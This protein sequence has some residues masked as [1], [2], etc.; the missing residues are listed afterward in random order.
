MID[1]TQTALLAYVAHERP[2]EPSGS[3]GFS[4]SEPVWPGTL[5]RGHRR[6]AA[7]II[8]ATVSGRSFSRSAISSSVF[9]PVMWSARARFRCASVHDSAGCSEP[10]MTPAGDGGL[11]ASPPA[12]P[13]PCVGDGG[14]ASRVLIATAGHLPLGTFVQDDVL[15]GSLVDAHRCDRQ[16]PRVLRLTVGLRAVVVLLSPLR[17]QHGPAG[18]TSNHRL[19]PPLLNSTIRR[20]P[21]NPLHGT[22]VGPPAGRQVRPSWNAGWTSGIP[23]TSVPSRRDGPP[24]CA[25]V[26]PSPIPHGL[27]L[28]RGRRTVAR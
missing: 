21:A 8:F 11:L 26:R 16:A 1:L 27:V 18:D 2:L 20:R 10:R 12:W 9:F 15:I 19:A 23:P 5:Y 6:F 17:M 25:R 3:G 14:G 7:T 28:R 24:A 22:G 13:R 4:L